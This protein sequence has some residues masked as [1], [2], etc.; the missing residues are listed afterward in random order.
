MIIATSGKG[1]MGKTT[2]LI[3]SYRYGILD[4]M[5]TRMGYNGVCFIDLD[6]YMILSR[7]LRTRSSAI[8]RV[9]TVADLRQRLEIDMA[10]GERPRVPDGTPEMLQLE[11]NIVQSCIAQ[12][13][14][15]VGH[16]D[17]GVI[18]R[19]V[20]SDAA[21]PSVPSVIEQTDGTVVTY[22]LIT[23]GT[24]T[25]GGSQCTPNNTMSRTLAQVVQSMPRT[26]F[27]IDNP[28]GIEP[29]GRYANIPPNIYLCFGNTRDSIQQE[30]WAQTIVQTFMM[31]W[32][33]VL[34]PGN[35]SAW[36]HRFRIIAIPSP[37]RSQKV[38]VPQATVLAMIQTYFNDPDIADVI[39]EI[40]VA[41][42]FVRNKQRLWAIWKEVEQA[43]Y[44]VGI[45]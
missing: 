12:W 43:L 41:P 33:T 1:S 7:R 39:G 20:P 40:T 34:D 29:F 32:R 14:R 2:F 35:P 11:W 16:Y 31:A 45:R 28:A 37:Y 38:V 3:Q 36:N 5:V 19:T 6:P 24:W 25:L 15:R 30:A 8:P 26:I 27:L 4:S 17:D 44:G 13:N 18:G 9:P 21:H 42:P 22:R 23:L 10:S